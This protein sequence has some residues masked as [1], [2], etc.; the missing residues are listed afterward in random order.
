MKSEHEES[1]FFCVLFSVL[2]SGKKVHKHSANHDHLLNRV[3]SLQIDALLDIR[4]ENQLR[5][6]RVSRLC[7]LGLQECRKGPFGFQIP[8]ILNPR[9]EWFQTHDQHRH[10]FSM[11][12]HAFVYA[13][14][15][16]NLANP[17]YHYDSTQIPLVS[18]IVLTT[19]L[20]EIARFAG[21]R[22]S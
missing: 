11:V 2:S 14:K 9:L 1:A 21:W 4:P 19:Q 13:T 17:E 15:K 10:A 7:Y 12:L 8:L 16:G 5:I 22:V 18:C 20:L 6:L 3:A